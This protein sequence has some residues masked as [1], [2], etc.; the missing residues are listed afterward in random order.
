LKDKDKFIV[1]VKDVSRPGIRPGK[2]LGSFRKLEF[3][4][5]DEYKLTQKE[6]IAENWKVGIFY[7]GK[8]IC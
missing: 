5:R 1:A 2:K 3:A 6:G 8:L 7:N 4:R